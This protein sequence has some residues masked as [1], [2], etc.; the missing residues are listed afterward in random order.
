MR[1]TGVDVHHFPLT[2]KDREWR[3]SS[4][5]ANQVDAFAIELHTDEGIT[6]VGGTSIMRIAGETAVGFVSLFNNLLAP[7]LIGKD[8]FDIEAIMAEVGRVCR[9]P[10]RAHVGIDLA[11]HDLMGKALNVPVYRLLGG[12][13]RKEVPIIR[14]VGIKEP[15]A[16]A[17]NAAD[18]VDEGYRYL[19]LKIGLDPEKDVQR[20]AAVRKAVGDDVVLT[21]DANGAYQ[22]FEAIWVLRRLQPYGVAV[23]EEP[24]AAWDLDGQARVRGASEIPIMADQSANTA[25]DAIEVI[26]RQSA[27]VL[28]V[29]VCKTGGILATRKFLAVAEAANIP[30]HIGSTATTRLLE[31]GSIHVAV[32]MKEIPHGCELGEFEGLEGDAAE[33]LSVKD[34]RLS[35]PEAPGLG[36][37]FLRERVAVR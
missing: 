28:A 31:A 11:L 20:V 18:L 10:L 3:T 22:P 7:A 1:I 17:R 25:A 8:P 19:K 15:A 24:T 21:I 29:K 27:D 36:V 13:F 37:T 12:A 35:V 30:C 5:G 26:K 2:R 34:G 6:G 23:A 33:G 16:Q 4:Y 14:M 9:E 32:T